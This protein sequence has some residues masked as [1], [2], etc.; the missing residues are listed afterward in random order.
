[1]KHHSLLLMVLQPGKLFANR[2]LTFINCLHLEIC[3][4]L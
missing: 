3:D 2:D 1:M 4:D